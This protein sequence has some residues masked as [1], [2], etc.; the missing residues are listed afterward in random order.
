MSTLPETLR[1]LARRVDVRRAILPP[2]GLAPALLA[3]ADEIE[4]QAARADRLRQDVDVLTA[5]AA[6]QSANVANVHG[7]VQ[8]AS[9]RMTAMQR[10]A[11]ALLAGTEAAGPALRELLPLLQPWLNA[12]RAAREALR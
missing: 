9:A 8:A 1:D 10:D 11:Q 3:A 5:H 7:V 6:E 4:R 2:P 12:A